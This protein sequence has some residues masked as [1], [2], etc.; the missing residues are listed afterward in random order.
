MVPSPL[1][2]PPLG[3]P[4]AEEDELFWAWLFLAA[5]S[6]GAAMEEE[7][8]P[9]LVQGLMLWEYRFLFCFLSASKVDRNS[10]LWLDAVGG[11]KPV[12]GL[13]KTPWRGF[14]QGWELVAKSTLNACS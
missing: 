11:S 2:C 9:Y 14:Q 7:T 10:V 1:F 6:E 3:A 8:S 12:S 13:I 4:L 5:C